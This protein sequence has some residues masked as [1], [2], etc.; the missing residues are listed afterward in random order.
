M[1]TATVVRKTNETDISLSLS[2]D[3]TGKTESRQAAAFLTTCSRCSGGTAV[4]YY[5]DLRRDT[6][7]DYHH[8]VEDI[9]ISLGKAFAQALGDGRA[10]A[11][12]AVSSC[13]WTRRSCSR[14]SISAADRSFPMTFPSPWKRWGISTR[15]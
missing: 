6:N 12:T 13:P 15:S 4:R 5:T 14:R 8:T 9:G 7:V 3:G 1:R 11:V 2:L 10:F